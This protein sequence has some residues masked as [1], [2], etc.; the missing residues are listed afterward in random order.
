MYPID[1]LGNR[2]LVAFRHCFLPAFVW[3][4][5]DIKVEEN[6]IVHEGFFLTP[7]EESIGLS[8]PSTNA[9]RLQLCPISACH[10][11][12]CPHLPLSPK[13]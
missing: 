13:D 11:A 9:R 8:N 12:S 2:C 3:I 6:L 5:P 1:K 10:L 4:L 7:L